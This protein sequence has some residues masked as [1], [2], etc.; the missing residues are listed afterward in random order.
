MFGCKK[1]CLPGDRSTD[2]VKVDVSELVEEPQMKI[3]RFEND[4]GKFVE[5]HG[6]GERLVVGADSEAEAM[7]LVKSWQQAMKRKGEEEEAARVK[8]EEERVRAQQRAEEEK[9]QQKAEAERLARAEAARLEEEAR[10]RRAAQE[11]Q[12]L[13]EELARR[14]QVAKEE[15][16]RRLEEEAKERQEVLTAF[17]KENGF[18]FGA[19]LNVNASKR[20]MMKTTYPLHCAAEAG[21][22]AIVDMLLKEGADPSHKNSAGRTAAE[23]AQKKDKK[24][25]HAEVLRL[26]DSTAMPSTCGA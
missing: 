2:T 18:P 21:R 6:S 26:L 15:E 5:V 11:R 1:L 20:T 22:S 14:D 25:S 13:E 4:E 8:A 17:L 9:R 19:P 12:R 24:G 10:Q 23:L 16:Q 7:E 3:E